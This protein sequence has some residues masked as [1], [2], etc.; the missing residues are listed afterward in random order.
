MINLINLMQGDCL[1]LMKGIPDAV[2]DMIV[3]DPPY[4]MN[5]QSNRRKITPQFE[6]I[7]GDV[8]I[9]DWLSGFVEESYRVMKENTAI[10]MFASWHNIDIFKQEFEK[11][12]KLKNIIV[13]NKNNHGSGDLKGAYAPKYELILY[14][15]KGRSTFR[16]KRLP[17]VQK[18]KKV[19]GKDMLHPT[20]KP[21]DMLE[22]FIKNNSDEGNI[23]LDPF[24]GSGTTG[25]ACKNLTRNFIGM[26]L[27]EM[28]FNKAKERIENHDP[29]R[30]GTL[31]DSN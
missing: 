31:N 19:N 20:Q 16:C 6:K 9:N 3:T 8:D 25:V 15:H 11:K 27:D 14:G 24:M 4:G 12:F 23:I 7:Q 21:I 10:Y 5:Y 18:Y 13:W 29:E 28:Y 2:V 1:E 22:I 26:E 17:D 30:R